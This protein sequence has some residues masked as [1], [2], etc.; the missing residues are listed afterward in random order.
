[1]KRQVIAATSFAGC[2]AMIVLGAMN[3]SGRSRAQATSP[4]PVIRFLAGSTVKMQ[5]LLGETDK[6]KHQPT[7][8][9]TETRYGIRG[10]DLGNSFE[11]NGRVYFLFGDTVGRLDHALDTIATTDATDPEQGVRLD[12]LMAG[13][14][15]LT[16][17]PPGISMGAFE[18]PVAGVS[19]GGQ[20]YVV[21]S[22]NHSQDGSTD[23]SV[24]TRFTLPATFQP[25]RTISQLPAG[26]F[27]K[28]SLH[29]QPGPIAGLPAG[30]P[31]VLAWGTGAY[32]QSDAY[33]SVVP[34]AQFETGKGAMYFAGMD[35]A[36]AP[37]WSANEAEVKPI[38][39]NGTLGDLSVTWCKD[40]G[41]WLMTYDRRAPTRGIAFSY[42][43]TPWGPWSEPQILFNVANDGIGKFI[44]N[45]NSN[46]PDGLAGPVIGKGQM[47]PEA[48][49]GGAY[50]PYVVER[51]T[52]LTGS[53]LSVYYLLSTWN[54]YVVVLMKSRLKVGP[55]SSS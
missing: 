19:L 11:H 26:R 28:M 7:L 10:T 15:Y 37:S 51:W 17:Q 1:M 12:F 50:A 54:P 29:T 23:R 27:V 2:L 16:I 25:L 38:V 45:P 41:L 32:R 24:L 48:V 33:L 5:Q 43:R 18:V 6:E 52:K 13:Q 8:S 14:D 44:H 30:G 35:A 31:F 36:G 49:R 21:V 9:L 3:P 39:Q 53:E 55:G 4:A 22:T 42:S 40:L 47:D 46:P 20:M 34:V